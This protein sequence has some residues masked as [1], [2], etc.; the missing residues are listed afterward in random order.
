MDPSLRWDDDVENTAE[1]KPGNLFIPYRSNVIPAQAG[2]PWRPS[3]S[4]KLV[5]SIQ[6]VHLQ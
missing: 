1:L 2:I 3:H 4:S 6:N 5:I